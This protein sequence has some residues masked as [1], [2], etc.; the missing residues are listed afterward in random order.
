MK[1][2][3]GNE[4][5]VGSMVEVIDGFCNS[6]ELKGFQ[7]RV[8]GETKTEALVQLPKGTPHTHN[9]HLTTLKSGVT[10][11]SLGLDTLRY[12][13][14]SEI[15]LFKSQGEFK[16]GDLVEIL[17]GISG[18]PEGTL[19]TILRVADGVSPEV[20]Y[21]DGWDFGDGIK[22]WH[23]SEKYLSLVTADILAPE[24]CVKVNTEAQY[25]ALMTWV[26][27]NLEEV[28]DRIGFKYPRCYSMNQGLK[29]TCARDSFYEE[30]G[31]RILDFSEINL[32]D[33][34]K[35]SEL[36]YRPTKPFS[37]RDVSG[38][39]PCDSEFDKVVCTATK[40]FNLTFNRP[41]DWTKEIEDCCVENGWISYL[42]SHGLIEKNE[43]EVVAAPIIEYDQSKVYIFDS[44]VY[45][46]QL[47]LIP[48]HPKVYFWT[49]INN[50]N[51]RWDS[52]T[53]STMEAAIKHVG[54]EL[55]QEFNSMKEYIQSIS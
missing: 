12:F 6:L 47:H 52:E 28:T 45:I 55:V 31:Y 7:G 19:T 48:G 9:G 25:Q 49:D 32:L 50:T 29:C 30:R 17:D 26:E 5:I 1:D 22:G 16:V 8:V 44:G 14:S 3:N 2:V 23:V 4:V 11:K 36:S 13:G 10:A 46:H 21:S 53:H 20:E 27:G 18:I 42:V 39:G 33:S 37:L 35:V 24:T 51:A 54:S 40:D 41:L 15:R 43:V 38:T 34:V